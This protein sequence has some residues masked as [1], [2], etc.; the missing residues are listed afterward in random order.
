MSPPARAGDEPEH[1]AALGDVAVSPR[2][3]GDNPF[4]TARSRQEAPKPS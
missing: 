1:V 3:S 2:A 4:P